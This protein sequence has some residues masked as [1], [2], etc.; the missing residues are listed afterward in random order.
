MRAA[1][2][3]FITENVHHHGHECI[4]WENTFSEHAR[5]IFFLSL[6]FSWNGETTHSMAL[7]SAHVHLPND[8]SAQTS[9][10]NA[11]AFQFILVFFFLATLV[12]RLF[13]PD[14]K[15]FFF[16]FFSILP[17]PRGK[18]R[19]CHKINNTLEM[20]SKHEAIR[21]NVLEW[22]FL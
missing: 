20:N 15:Q 5:T 14:A 18:T 22:K 1:A 16:S 19:S 9:A 2:H 8:R 11:R 4:V 17:G 7:H 6:S 21:L 10:C 13:L 3:T 12:C